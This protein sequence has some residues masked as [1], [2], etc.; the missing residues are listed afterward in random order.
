MTNRILLTTLESFKGLQSDV[1]VAILPPEANFKIGNYTTILSSAKKVLFIINRSKE[2]HQ[3]IR[4]E[5]Q[6]GRF[7]INN[8]FGLL[9]M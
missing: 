6:M 2:F 3:F 7:Q 4:K 5:Q 1:L 8:D 9:M